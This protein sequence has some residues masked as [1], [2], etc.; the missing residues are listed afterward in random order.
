MDKENGDFLGGC[1]EVEGAENED[2]GE[3]RGR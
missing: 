3:G 2:I 1:L